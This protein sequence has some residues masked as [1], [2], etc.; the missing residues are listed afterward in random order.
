MATHSSVLPSEIP[1]RRRRAATVHGVARSRTRLSEHV[2]VI[3]D[4][5]CGYAANLVG[6]CI[7]FLFFILEDIFPF[8]L[9]I[10]YN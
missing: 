6:K 8:N 3:S 1:W 7:H 10:F 4:S 9:V 2:H 5:S